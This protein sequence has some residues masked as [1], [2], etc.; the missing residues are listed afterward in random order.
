MLNIIITNKVRTEHNLFVI[1]INWPVKLW[2][3]EGVRKPLHLT[4]LD[5]THTSGVRKIHIYKT[6]HK[7]SEDKN[8]CQT[9]KLRECYEYLKNT[10]ETK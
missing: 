10:E 1:K 6:K 3:W 9:Y 4:Y 7:L 2:L 5:I 8:H